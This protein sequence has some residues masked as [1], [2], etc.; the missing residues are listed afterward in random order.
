LPKAAVHKLF[1]NHMSVASIDAAVGRLVDQG[2]ARR[3][4]RLTGGRPSEVV[5]A[6]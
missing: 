4:S 3:E 2:L 6:V 1:N 5:M